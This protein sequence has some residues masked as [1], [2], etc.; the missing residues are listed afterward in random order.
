MGKCGKLIFFVL[1]ILS[2]VAFYYYFGD[3]L[4]GHTILW[5][6]LENH[7]DLVAVTP[8]TEKQ[9]GSILVSRDSASSLSSETLDSLLIQYGVD[10]KGMSEVQQKVDLLLKLSSPEFWRKNYALHPKKAR[11][12]TWLWVHDRYLNQA[13]AL[14]EEFKEDGM[15]KRKLRKKLAKFT[16][17]L[18][19]HSGYEEA[20]MF[21]FMIEHLKMEDDILEVLTNEH[22]VIH[23]LSHSIQ[24]MLDVEE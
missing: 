19:G 6:E 5:S 14:Y 13:A 2:A 22:P 8:N 11:I 16:K 12:K 21:K 18:G 15:K 24:E 23:G 1:S 3:E 20:M 10:P 7:K 17:K 4:S 9:F